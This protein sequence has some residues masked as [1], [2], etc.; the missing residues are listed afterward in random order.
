M[1][2]FGGENFQKR[3]HALHRMGFFKIPRRNDLLGASMGSAVLSSVRGVVKKYIFLF[4]LGISTS[5]TLEYQD[6]GHLTPE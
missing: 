1:Y 4:F 2:L 6:F 3:C 5:G